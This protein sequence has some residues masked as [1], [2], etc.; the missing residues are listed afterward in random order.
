MFDGEG[1]EGD[2]DVGIRTGVRAFGNAANSMQIWT[3]L[4]P[5]ETNWQ[6]FQKLFNDDEDF[7]TIWDQLKPF[8]T[9]WNQLKPIGNTSRHYSMMMRILEPFET[10]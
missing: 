1:N 2:D 7:E 9:K 6:R 8:Q 4:P 3:K 10:N 5:S